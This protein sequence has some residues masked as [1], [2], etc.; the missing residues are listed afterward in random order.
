[1]EKIAEKLA[2][3][4]WILRSGGAVGADTAFEKGAKKVNDLAE[5]YRPENFDRSAENIEFCDSYLR[6]IIDKGRN[7]DKFRIETKTL[8]RRNVHQILGKPKFDSHE[9]PLKEV[10]GIR[11]LDSRL[12]VPVKFVVF[13]IPTEDIWAEDA[14]G[15]KY[16]VRIASKLNIPLFNLFSLKDRK[17]LEEWITKPD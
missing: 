7:F 1:M 10:C 5:I 3:N 8:L 2:K 12:I 17:R 14:G 11:C 13:W 6:P 16:A 4:S 15:T 9:N